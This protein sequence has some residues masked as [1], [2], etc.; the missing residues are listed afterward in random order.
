MR[1]VSVT[2]IAFASASLWAGETQESTAKRLKESTDVLK[3]LAGSKDKGVP[4][5]LFQKSKCA[6]VIPGMK[7]GGF[8]VG[9]EY[10]RGFVSCKDSSG[11]FTTLSAVRLEGGSFGLQVGGAATDVLMLVMNDKGA[12]RLISS[13]FKLGGDASVAAGP[14]GREAS[15]ETDATMKAEI[16]SWSRSQGVFGGLSLN[17][18]TLRTD[19]D[20]IKS[21]YGQELEPKQ[22]LMAGSTPP[23]E[24]AS[25]FLAQLNSLTSAG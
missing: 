1:L 4:S 23:P 20:T 8:I 12:E 17:G 13:Q 7:K 25:D 19:K 11:K 6:V 15:A 16:L 24:M 5:G 22:L 14:V 2:L 3:E 21:L 18:S 10:G 9:G